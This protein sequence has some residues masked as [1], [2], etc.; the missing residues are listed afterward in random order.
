MSAM[1][2]ESPTF[3]DVALLYTSFTRLERPS[4]RSM[5]ACRSVSSHRKAARKTEYGR[6]NV[7]KKMHDAIA[8]AVSP[9]ISAMERPPNKLYIA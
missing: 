6:I 3:T 5:L 4:G 8:V 1:R 9:D 2:S 7:D